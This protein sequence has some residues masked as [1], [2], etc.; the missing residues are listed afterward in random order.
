MLV[1]KANPK[2]RAT[3]FGPCLTSTY[4]AIYLFVG[5]SGPATGLGLGVARV[6]KVNAK[7]VAFVVRLSGP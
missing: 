5:E 6:R 1:F 2:G 4:G 7:L 3:A